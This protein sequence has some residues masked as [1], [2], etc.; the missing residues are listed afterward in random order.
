MMRLREIHCVMLS[1]LRYSLTAFACVLCLF[2]Q[3]SHSE[4]A[5][6]R[7]PVTAEMVVIAMRYRQ[8][9]TDGVEVRLSAPMTASS[10][11]PMLDIQ[12]MT[13]VDAHSAQL[14]IACRV[15]SEC[16]PFYVAARWPAA[17]GLTIPDALT[18]KTEALAKP[19]EL[20]SDG[21]LKAGSI[22]TLMIEDEKVHIRLQVICLNGGVTGDRIHVSTPDRKIAYEAEIVSPNLLKG[23]F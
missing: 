15:R 1:T 22:A 10:V 21:M 9:P 13:M 19:G 3:S 7:F 17:T 16:L 11:N 20:S 12:T 2:P 14:R 6:R 23:S 5:A 8:L 18:H 4:S